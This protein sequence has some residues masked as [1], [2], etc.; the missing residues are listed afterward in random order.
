M[1][2]KLTDLSPW[3]TRSWPRKS[4]DAGSS[5]QEVGRAEAAPG[6]RGLMRGARVYL[7]LSRYPNGKPLHLGASL[8]RRGTEQHL[9]G[10]PGSPEDPEQ[11]HEVGEPCQSAPSRTAHYRTLGHLPLTAGKVT[12][13]RKVR[14]SVQ[15][16]ITFP[17]P[18]KKSSSF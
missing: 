5:G 2:Q 3:E 11:G 10:N 12:D 18:C 1:K 6:K 16:H 15:S 17:S 7:V 4:P 8:P 13:S 9:C 14:L